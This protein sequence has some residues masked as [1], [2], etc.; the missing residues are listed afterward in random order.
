MV[1]GSVVLEAR[2]VT[3]SFPGV[4]ALAGVDL[5]CQAAY[6]T[7]GINPAELAVSHGLR[8]TLGIY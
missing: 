3:K 8:L 4:R 5:Y 1:A 2:G 6:L 7:P